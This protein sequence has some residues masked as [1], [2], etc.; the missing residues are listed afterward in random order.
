MAEP[1]EYPP[2][3]RPRP[4]SLIPETQRVYA[5]L[6]GARRQGAWEPAE[7]VH[8]FALWGGVHLDFRKADLLEGETEVRVV[9][10]MGGVDLIVPDDV[11]V[12]VDGLGI[13]GGFPHLTHRADQ[14]D[15]PTIRVG[16]FALWGGVN[17]KVRRS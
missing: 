10:L 14:S 4:E 2:A 5:V 13:M 3:P 7:T 11:D 6:G 16:G 8:V 1:P 9:A 12:I 17:V 15:A